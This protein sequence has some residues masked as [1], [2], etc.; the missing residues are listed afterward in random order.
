MVIFRNDDVSGSSNYEDIKQMYMFLDEKFNEPEIWSCV[1]LFSRGKCGSV[2]P[3]LPLSQHQPNWFFN[4][5]RFW[6]V[7]EFNN[8]VIPSSNHKIVSHGLYHVKHAHLP[9]MAQEMSIV[10]SCNYLG[11]KIF[12]PPFTNYNED[13]RT[14]CEGNDI[15]LVSDRDGWKSLE[16]EPFNPNHKLWF[17]HSWRFT[18]K[19]FKE[20]FK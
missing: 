13:T 1:N 6:N 14:I 18:P 8:V 11:T 16:S 19:S 15:Q 3:E 2:Y 4:A 7:D 9:Y 10:G 5:T 17:F 12:V 20:L